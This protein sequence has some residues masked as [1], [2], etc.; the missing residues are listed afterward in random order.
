MATVASWQLHCSR[1]RVERAWNLKKSGFSAP[2]CRHLLHGMHHDVIVYTADSIAARL[3]GAF[4]VDDPLPRNRV[5]FFTCIPN[6]KQ[7][8]YDSDNDRQPDLLLPSDSTDKTK[9]EDINIVSFL[10]IP[11]VFIYS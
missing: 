4:S 6:R 9:A 10:I 2:W 7:Y 1:A 3:K 8:F 5:S 11:P